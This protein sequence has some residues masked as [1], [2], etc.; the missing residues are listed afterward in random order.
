MIQSKEEIVKALKASFEMVNELMKGLSSEELKARFEEKW[1]PL[2]QFDHL[3]RSN[4]SIGLLLKLPK[5]ALMIYGKSD[6]GSRTFD[7]V[8]EAYLNNLKEGG[9]ASG[10]YIPKAEA[11]VNDQLL[12]WR[13]VGIDIQK[14]LENWDEKDLDRYRAPHPLLGKMTVREL[15]FFTVYHNQYHVNSIKTILTANK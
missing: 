13:K 1:T 7:G 10:D 15:L 5:V 2:Q 9:K 14:N 6:N 11:S 3:V 12:K 4:K 8:A